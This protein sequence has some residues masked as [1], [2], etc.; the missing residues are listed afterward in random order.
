VLWF[1]KL[2]SGIDITNIIFQDD[3]GRHVSE[4]VLVPEF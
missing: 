4:N 2:L 3:G 1:F